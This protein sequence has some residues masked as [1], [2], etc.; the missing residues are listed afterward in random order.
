MTKKLFT[1]VQ[2]IAFKKNGLSEHLKEIV[3]D[4]ERLLNWAVRE[5]IISPKDAQHLNDYWR[6]VDDE[7]L[8]I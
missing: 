4:D 2:E 6:K 8:F 1:F 5:K 3:I 7:E